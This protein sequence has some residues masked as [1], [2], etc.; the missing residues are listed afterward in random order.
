MPGDTDPRGL[1]A[2]FLQPDSA[3]DED[4]YALTFNVAGISFLLR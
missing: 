2:A 1:L 4:K 3:L